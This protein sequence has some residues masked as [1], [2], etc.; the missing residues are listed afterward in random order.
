MPLRTF[1]IIKL[2]YQNAALGFS[3]KSGRIYISNT[4]I[5][6]VKF[7]KYKIIKPL[8]LKLLNRRIQPMH[9]LIKHLSVLGNLSHCVV[10]LLR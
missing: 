4:Y 9:N 7:F 8:Q 1:S 6:P 5:L 10:Y 2:Q 3:A